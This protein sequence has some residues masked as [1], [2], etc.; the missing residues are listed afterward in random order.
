MI[1][2]SQ[3]A[4]GRRSLVIQLDKLARETCFARDGHKC[5]RCVSRKVQWCHIV[6]RRHLATRWEPDNNLSMCAGCHMWWHEY[7]LLSGPW[8]KK[9]WPE[10]AEHILRLH[11]AGGGPKT[12]K[13]L[14]ELLDGMTLPPSVVLPVSDLSNLP[15]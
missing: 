7:P 12:A 10:R 1:R 5:V 8:F 9:N 6:G 15:F 3:K 11:N 13:D 2:S 4:R 14:Q